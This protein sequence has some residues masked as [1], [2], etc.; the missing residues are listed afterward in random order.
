MCIDYKSLNN[1]CI[2]DIF[3]TPFSGNVFDNVVGNEAYPFAEGFSSYHHAG[4][5]KEE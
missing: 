5:A 3:P 2:H 4:I 1:V